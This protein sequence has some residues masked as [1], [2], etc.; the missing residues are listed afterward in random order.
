LQV[1]LPLQLPVT[2]SIMI[3]ASPITTFLLI[4]NVPAIH[5]GRGELSRA[6]AKE[7]NRVSLYEDSDLFN[8][9]SFLSRGDGITHMAARWTRNSRRSCAGGAL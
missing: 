6:E 1:F 2:K 8:R 3:K 9:H 4:G 5:A 7:M